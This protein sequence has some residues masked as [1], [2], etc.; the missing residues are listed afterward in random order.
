MAKTKERWKVLKYPGYDFGDRYMISDHAKIKDL[1]TGEKINTKNCKVAN[2]GYLYINLV[3]IN[4]K[5]K[6][7]RHYKQRKEE[8]HVHR[9]MAYNFVT[10]D[11]QGMSVH[12]KDHNRKNNRPDN[13]LVCTQSEHNRL[14]HDPQGENNRSAKLTNEEVH[15]ICKML[16]SKKYTHKEIVKH[17]NKTN[18]KFTLSSLEKISAKKNWTFISDQYDITPAKREHMGQFKEDAEIIGCMKYHDYSDREIATRLGYPTDPYTLSRL[19]DCGKRY[20]NKYKRFYWGL[21]TKEK[22]KAMLNIQ[23]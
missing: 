14:Y 10:K 22:A 1:I 13:L 23:R 12:H 5:P 8:F 15:E 11:I 16:E 20:L 6:G 21:C 19:R 17:I 2:M 7:K 4:P 9:L 3:T 18:P